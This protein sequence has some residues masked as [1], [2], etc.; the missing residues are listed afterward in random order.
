MVGLAAGAGGRLGLRM[1]NPPA[2]RSRLTSRI[3]PTIPRRAVD[4]DDD[5]QPVLNARPVI[6]LGI[7]G[8]L[9]VNVVAIGATSRPADL[10]PEGQGTGVGLLGPA[11]SAPWPAPASL[12]LRTV[13]PLGSLSVTVPSLSGGLRHPMVVGRVLLLLPSETYPGGGLLGC[14]QSPR[15]RGRGRLR[16]PPGDGGFDGRPGRSRPSERNRTTPCLPS[17][18]YTPRHRSMPCWPSTIRG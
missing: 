17:W 15:G 2:S 18:R 7:L 13:T 5:R 1:L 11:I 12:K 14:R 8:R 3:E 9:E 4:G 10:D 6:R 16:A